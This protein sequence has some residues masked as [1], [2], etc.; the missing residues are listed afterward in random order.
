MRS[1][2]RGLDRRSALLGGLGALGVSACD[3]QVQGRNALSSPPGFT[4]PRLERDAMGAQ[5]GAK[6][7]LM[8][9]EATDGQGGP[10]EPW[11]VIVGLHGMDDYA[12]ALGLAGPYWAEQGVTTYAYDQR[13]F[14]GAPER[15][16]WAGQALMEED[17]RCACALVR[18]RH[19]RAVM[20]VVGESM[21]G[22]VGVTAFASTRP[23][24]AERL[25]LASPAVWG[26]REQGAANSVLL[27]TAAH[28]APSSAVSAPGWLA[29][30]IRASDN[31]AELRRMGTDRRMIFDTRIDAI[32][33]LVD[34][35]QAAQDQIGQVRVPVLYQ[36]GAHDDIIPKA[37]AFHAAA[38]LKPG[39]RTAYYGG[40]WHLLL[41]DL[42]RRR[43]LN[44]V[45]AFTRNPAGP[46][47]SGAPAIPLRETHESRPKKIAAQ[48]PLQA[49]QP[50]AG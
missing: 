22:A 16:V 17:L 15:G 45:L 19:P 12:A 3:P 9:W 46:I 44:D 8:R 50:G 29:R 6:L 38:R 39:D 7:P 10:V 28:I 43:V 48:V 14:G 32:Y 4:G 36:Y 33:G 37:A 40:G 41:R 5:D 25:V 35:M 2:E 13:G 47:P 21:G 27:W 30:K 18:A 42:G 20:T 11:A 49:G 26:W 24:D 23:P 1:A 34:L 31:V